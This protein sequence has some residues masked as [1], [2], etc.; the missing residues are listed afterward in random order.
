MFLL[1][2]MAMGLF[3]HR[4]GSVLEELGHR[5]VRHGRLV[6]VYALKQILVPDE[7]RQ[8]GRFSMTPDETSVK[9]VYGLTNELSIPVPTKTFAML[10]RVLESA[11]EM[12]V[13]VL[14]TRR[15]DGRSGFAASRDSPGFGGRVALFLDAP[16]RRGFNDSTTAVPLLT[17]VEVLSSRSVPGQSMIRGGEL[18]VL[19]IPEERAFLDALER[20][21]GR[22]PYSYVVDPETER[23]MLDPAVKADLEERLGLTSAETQ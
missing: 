23:T 9:V 13:V 21:R 4:R 10:E 19:L 11:P 2:Y 7:S 16:D 18:H 8:S 20:V 14:R 6:V 17:G 1:V 15:D 3:E 5:E 22:A 12:E